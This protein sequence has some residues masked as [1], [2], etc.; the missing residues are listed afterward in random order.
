MEDYDNKICILVTGSRDWTYKK[1][2]EDALSKLKSDIG[3]VILIHGNCV[4]LDKIAGEIGI[5]LGFEIK[6]MDADWN[7]YKKAAG[8]IRNKQMIDEL[9]KYKNKHFLAFHDNLELS[10]GTKNCVS[11]AFKCGIVAEVIKH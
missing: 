2:V 10:K 9:L 3:D 5:K 11:Q 4:G 1:L 7:K 6:V 8:P